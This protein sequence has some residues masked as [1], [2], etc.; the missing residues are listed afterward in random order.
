MI[1]N[2]CVSLFLVCCTFSL[3]WVAFAADVPES[4]FF[5]D[6]SSM[7]AS[8]ADWIDYFYFS[9]NFQQKMR[10][11]EAIILP[12]P[13]IFMAEDSAYKG[14][15]VDDMMSLTE[16]MRQLVA[17]AFAD[18]YQ[19]ASTPGPNTLVVRMAF[20]NFYL[21]KKSR[22]LFGYTPVGF[23]VTNAKR[24]M[25]NEFTEN[26]L[27]TEL[28]WEAELLDSETGEVL[29]QVYLNIG[30]H[31]D[32]DTFTSWDELVTVMGDASERLRCRFDNAALNAS[33]R[34]EC[35]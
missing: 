13:E 4:G 21:K 6:Y 22:G 5:D 28:T 30:E 26:I 11:A 1:K 14:M 18:G 9:D 2:N 15:K 34:Q 29:A 17:D 35:N 7:Q 23:V 8:E 25:L 31:S 32:K 16:S 33:A 12:Q 10:S 19:I 20:S 24:T 27:L 3:N